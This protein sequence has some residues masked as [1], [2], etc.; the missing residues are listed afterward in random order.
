MRN[1][2]FLAWGLAIILAPN[3]KEMRAGAPSPWS[4]TVADSG[5]RTYQRHTDFGTCFVEVRANTP[6]L[7]AAVSKT[8]FD[9]KTAEASCLKILEGLPDHIL[10]KLASVD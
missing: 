3:I 7:F 4:V 5:L 2:V 8:G 6:Q 1:A 10:E 9:G